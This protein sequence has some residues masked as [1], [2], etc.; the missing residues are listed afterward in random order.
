MKT[1]FSASLSFWV[2]CGTPRACL[3]ASGYRRW[4]SSNLLKSRQSIL[5]A[6]FRYDVDALHNTIFSG[7]TTGCD[8]IRCKI[9]LGVCSWPSNGASVKKLAFSLLMLGT[10]LVADSCGAHTRAEVW[11]IP[12]GYVGWLRLDYS[13][14]GAVSL[15][16][17]S[18]R[19]VVKMPPSG[20]LQTS[21]ENRPRSDRNSYF[22]VVGDSRRSIPVGAQY[23]YSVRR[24]FAAGSVQ[25][26]RNR[27]I[28]LWQKPQ[29]SLE[30]VY[31][32]NDS[33][34]KSNGRDC[35]D[36]NRRTAR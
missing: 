13:V 1:A 12:P 7:G 35:T 28:R 21:S 24:A 16:I 11:L 10:I 9:A 25:V 32:G 5:T 19:Y 14:K 22:T 3:A 2:H 27:S 6:S 36:W 18:G 15:P 29:I 4:H 33:D 34:G 30:C 20:R 8:R 17:E 26:D 31:I 23:G